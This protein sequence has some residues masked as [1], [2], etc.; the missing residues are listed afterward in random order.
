M[1]CGDG[2]RS[3]RG[4]VVAGRCA[5]TSPRP[6]TNP[7]KI[8]GCRRELHLGLQTGPQTPLYTLALTQILTVVDDRASAGNG[9]VAK[10]RCRMAPTWTPTK[11]SGSASASSS[12]ASKPASQADA[13]PRSQASAARGTSSVAGLHRAACCSHRRPR[14]IHLRRRQLQLHLQG[15]CGW[16]T[17]G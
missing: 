6:G 7:R 12:T 8:S 4:G 10:V 13:W 16:R 5:S 14:Q 3:G 1:S 9:P 2:V 15:G 17:Q 11:P